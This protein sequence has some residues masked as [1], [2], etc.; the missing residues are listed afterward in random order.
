MILKSNTTVRYFIC[1][2]FTMYIFED[3]EFCSF[4]REEEKMSN[5][6]CRVNTVS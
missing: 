6:V 2:D 4:T 1:Y 5:D 3:D